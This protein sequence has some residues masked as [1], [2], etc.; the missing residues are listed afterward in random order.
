VLGLLWE[1]WNLAFVPLRLF[2]PCVA[3]EFSYSDHWRAQQLLNN[4]IIEKMNQHEWLPAPEPVAFATSSSGG[5]SVVVPAFRFLD[6][7]EVSTVPP[8]N[9]V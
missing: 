8:V 1:T 7:A 3:K 4:E 2:V 6:C 5:D 9:N